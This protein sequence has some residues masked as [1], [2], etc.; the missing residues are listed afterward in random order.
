MLFKKILNTINIYHCNIN[1]TY[2][3]N[4]NEKLIEIYN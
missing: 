4:V 2:F 3:F 1:P